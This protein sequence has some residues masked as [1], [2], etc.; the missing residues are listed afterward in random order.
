M[1]AGVVSRESVRI[2]F[3]YAALNG[4]DVYA[5]D[6]RNAYLQAPSSQKD[7]IV[8]GPEFGIENVG[9]VALI[10][11]VLYGGKSAGKDF[12]NH[13]RSCMRHLDFVSC[14]ADPD[15][16]MR[17][18]KRSDGTDYYEYILLYTDDALVLSE[19]AEKVLEQRSRALFHTK[20]GIDRTP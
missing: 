15:V 16:W 4:I 18:A 12:R 1:Y 14:P 5:A 13:L 11:R 20:R 8:C 2:A 17:P 10:H 19:N 3:T 9:K 7:Y 6:I